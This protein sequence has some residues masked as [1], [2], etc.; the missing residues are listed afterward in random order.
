[1]SACLCLPFWLKIYFIILIRWSSSQRRNQLGWFKTGTHK[2]YSWSR[3]HYVSPSFSFQRFY[4]ETEKSSPGKSVNSFPDSFSYHFVTGISGFVTM[5]F[6][7]TNVMYLKVFS[8][9]IVVS[10]SLNN[11]WQMVIDF[12]SLKCFLFF[13]SQCYYRGT[14]VREVS[15]QKMEDQDDITNDLKHNKQW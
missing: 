14:E 12:K 1:M 6:H 10:C 3:Q 8:N 4:P 15:A 2:L 5:W 7:H 11:L 13:K 9:S